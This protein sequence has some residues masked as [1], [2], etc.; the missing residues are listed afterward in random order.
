MGQLHFKRGFFRLW[1][2]F[3]CCFAAAVALLCWKDIVAEFQRAASIAGGPPP[4]AG[5]VIDNPGD[6]WTLLLKVLCIALGVPAVV[7]VIGAALGWALAGFR[8]AKSKVE[9]ARL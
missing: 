1:V 7:L 3:A 5:Y 8:E 4:P 6:P 2:I 9:D